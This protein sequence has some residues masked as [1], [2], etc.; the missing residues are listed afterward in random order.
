MTQKRAEERVTE[1]EEV[2][3]AV[4]NLSAVVARILDQLSV[5]SWLP[6]AFM[7]AGASILLQFHEQRN[8]DIPR[9][10]DSLTKEP[11]QVLVIIVPL[12]VLATMITQAFSFQAIRILEGYGLS[13]GPV[14]K[15][16]RLMISRQAVRK[17]KFQHRLTVKED[18]A[19]DAACAQMESAGVDNL[20]VLAIKERRSDGK[21]KQKLSSEQMDEVEATDWQL[22]AYPEDLAVIDRLVERLDLYPSDSRIMPTDLG[23]CLR[24]FEDQLGD[25]AGDVEGFVF[26]ARGRATARLRMHH[27][28]FRDRLDMYCTLVF[29]SVG[30]AFG[31]LLLLTDPG[32]SRWEFISTSVFF[33][34]VAL[35]SYRSAIHS[36]RGY[37][38]V[39]MLMAEA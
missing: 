12:L 2:P 39:L 33:I 24:S 25:S 7:V 15:I 20:I 14:S 1:P 8:S 27:D 21:V 16:Q 29:V 26:H 28:Q 35:I 13:I 9:A 4:D 6:A 37:G 38:Q 36:A 19:F 23:N 17:N 3:A 18:D 32:Y 22:Y 30:L 31:S 10:I 34:L 5:T 11:F